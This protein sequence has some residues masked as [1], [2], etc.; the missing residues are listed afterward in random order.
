MIYGYKYKSLDILMTE[1]YKSYIPKE[2]SVFKIHWIIK[3]WI[4]RKSFKYYKW[5]AEPYDWN[6]A[7]CCW[8]YYYLDIGEYV[9]D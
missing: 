7:Y 1:P 2:L 5:T 4:I 3:R 8:I 9:V 6:N